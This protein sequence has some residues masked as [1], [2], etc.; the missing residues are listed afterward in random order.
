[1]VPLADFVNHPLDGVVEAN[2][3]PSYDVD[4]GTF[5]FRAVRAIKRGEGIYWDYGFKSNR[6]SLLRYGFASQERVALT[7]M[8]LFFRLTD[9]PGAPGTSRGL[10]LDLIN[11]SQLG[12]SLAMEDD[13][14]VMHEL[15]LSLAGPDARKLLGHMRFMV[16]EARSAASLQELCPATYCQPVGLQNE[17]QAL[18]LLAGVLETLISAYN[19]TAAEDQELLGDAAAPERDFAQ[20]C[21]VVVRYGEK[22]I[23]RGFTRLLEALDPLFDLSPWA[24]AAAVEKKWSNPA[25]DIHQY[26]RENLTSLVETEAL[27]WAKRKVKADRLKAQS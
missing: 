19:T 18:K 8:P 7:D 26:V 5:R 20:W 15:T 16:F 17:R 13:G 24:L 25:S 10:K 27:R 12:G 22:K 11:A 2:V 23:L 21:A 6:H 14:T 4:S 3:A 9:F 1:M